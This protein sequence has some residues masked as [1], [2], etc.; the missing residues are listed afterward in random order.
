MDQRKAAVTLEIPTPG[1]SRMSSESFLRTETV[2]IDEVSCTAT[3]TVQWFLENR[4]KKGSATHPITHNNKLDLFICGQAAFAEIAKDIANAKESI[5]LVCWGFDPGMELVR[6]GN[7]WPRGETYG[8][9]LIA[10]GRR[11]VQVRIL[12]WYSVAGSKLQKNMPGYSHGTSPW[13]SEG[14]ELEAQKIHARR[15]VALLREHAW[16]RRHK[17]EW[18][19]SPERFAEIAREEYCHSWY[20]A[21]FDGL[22]KGISIRTRDGDSEKIGAALAQEKIKPDFTERKVMKYGGT[23]HQK[24]ILIDFAY[25]NGQ[26]AIGY[27]MG[28]NSVTSYWDT[29]EHCV[30]NSLREDGGASTQGE[31]AQGVDDYSVFQTVKPYRDYACR[32]AGGQA[33]I[34]I[35]ENFERAWERAGKVPKATNYVCTQPPT[36]LLRKASQVDSTVQI[37]RT[38]PEEDD[39]TIKDIYFN[40]TRVAAAGAGYLYI[41]NQ[42]F[43]YQEWADYLLA[44][45]KKVI[46]GWKR[47]CAKIGKTMEDLPMMHVFVVI[48]APELAEMIP[49]TYDT[50]ATLG[51]QDG[52]I[53]QVKMID[54]KNNEDRIQ[55]S[56][57]IQPFFGY[58]VDMRASQPKPL[59]D[60]VA[61]ANKIEK[62]T[63]A[64]LEDQFGLRV[65]V[66]VL[67]ACE[68]HQA[69]RKWR[70]REIYIHSKLMLVDDCFF[71]LGSANLNQRSMAVDSEI[72]LATDDPRHAAAL[73]VKIWSKLTGGLHSGGDCTNYEVKE[74]LKNW[75]MLMKINKARQKSTSLLPE[76]KQ[77]EGYIVPLEDK[78]SSTIRL[79]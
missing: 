42:Y 31:R 55:N 38:Q 5:D 10:A 28:L 51:Q 39:F 49:R 25:K 16:E 41:E 77:M 19:L 22:L 11:G 23:H 61:T 64:V 69:T 72:N 47:N 32:L 36:G 46:A 67:N 37:V 35:H 50:L 9:L 33:L 53:G 44:T 13:R 71:T 14:G 56:M 21:A 1:E 60:V 48:P 12:V 63:A 24:P 73:R 8:D 75:G 34:P 15:S 20:E 4:N 3:S 54:R 52:L 70:Y 74:T 59:P 76:N 45:R 58:G 2:H 18:N 30:E 29:G 57:T 79:G 7:I 43:Q 40:A 26:K 65:C 27:V 66:A 62:P 6:E 78:R 17:T 68:F